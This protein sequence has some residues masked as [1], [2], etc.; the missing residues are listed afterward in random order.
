MD[1]QKVLI[2]EDHRDMLVVL[3]KYLEDQEFDIIEAATGEKGLEQFEK[4]DPD[5][6]L[7]DIMLPGISGLEVIKK[8]KEKRNTDKYTP[9]IIITAKNDKYSDKSDVDYVST[10]GLSIFSFNKAMLN[11]SLTLSAKWK[12]KPLR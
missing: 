2:V 9:I 1:K 12:V 3:R 5:L 6:I 4:H 7:L 11:T 10:I 8:I